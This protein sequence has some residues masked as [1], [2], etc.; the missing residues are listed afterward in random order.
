MLKPRGLA[1]LAL[2]LFSLVQAGSAEQQ[3]AAGGGQPNAP[4]QGATTEAPNPDDPQ[5]TFRAGINFVRVDVIITDR[6]RAPVTDLTQDDFEVLEDGRAQTIEQFRLVKVDGVPRPGD[7]P[8][9]RIRS[10]DDEQQEASRED[11]RIFAILL[12]DYHVRK[13]TAMSV[14][15]PLTEFIRLRLQPNDLLAVMYPLTPVRE[16]LFTNDHE[17]IIRAIEN[18]EGRKH[19]Y[20]PRN[21]FEQQY[22]RLSTQDVERVRNDVVMGALKALSVRLGSMREGRKS[23]IYVSEGLTAM[24]PPQF[25]RAD[26]S[27][28]AVDPFTLEAQAAAQD[29]PQQQTAEWF[30]QSQLYLKMREVFQ[31]A[32][33]NNTSI[34]SLDPRGLAVF[35]YDIDAAP[36]LAA[37]PSFATDRRVLQASQDTLRVFAEQTDG[38]AIVNQNDLAGG[39]AQMVQDSSVYYLLGYT[40][41]VSNDGKFHEL[42]VRVKRP[43]VEVRARPGFWA[44]TVDDVERVENPT[45][46]LAKPVAQ[47]LATLAAASPISGKY[48]RTWVGTAR[49]ENGKTR[50][51]LV[52]E[53]L[54]QSPGA[55]R[56]QP[57]R[58]SLLAANAAG[59]L[60]YR[61]SSPD[62]ALASAGPAT[63][64]NDT[65]ATGVRVP[66]A[67]AA[68]APQ[69]IVFDAAPGEIELRMTV[70]E[71]STGG[72]LD[73]EIKTLDVP[74]LT[75]P[76][77]AIST[78][79][80]FRGR[81]ARDIQVVAADP[82][83][84]PVAAREFSRTERLL[85]RFDAYAA[86]G[87]TPTATAALLNRSGDRMSD[88]PVVAAPAGGTHQINMGLASVPAGDYLVEITVTSAAGEVKELVALRVTS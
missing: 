18:F 40:S 59:D 28:P 53:P 76:Q 79:R 62:T 56:E 19:D 17:S 55:R 52:W 8:P 36:T 23:I 48:V 7:P 4:A 58:V 32:N 77:T 57:G 88:V 1:F 9:R 87:E 46:E 80:V 15:N 45:P 41:D 39:L 50:V 30:E 86:G 44:L 61:G 85:I 63:R 21:V 75:A 70:Q 68:A 83:A 3:P 16:L 64:P 26:A 29:S 22:A 47:A 5:T 35:E 38:R 72:T 69:R 10:R 12:D 66:A 20:T 43:G 25:Q 31:D 14:K 33:R 11:V 51:T 82:N 67:A 13:S 74:D 73:Q 37:M 84:V 71:A 60:V 27:R 54:P 34:Y 2:L 24:L 49:G 6:Q 78:P 65:G 42:K 81:T